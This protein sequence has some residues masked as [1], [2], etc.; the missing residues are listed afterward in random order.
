MERD[1]MFTEDHMFGA[2]AKYNV[3]E[4]PP[5]GYG[6][7][8]LELG[9]TKKCLHTA[10]CYRSVTS[11]FDLG[12][13]DNVCQIFQSLIAVQSID[14]KRHRC[15]ER[16]NSLLTD[17]AMLTKLFLHSGVFYH[18]NSGL[19]GISSLSWANESL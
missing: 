1:Y 17:L 14:T 3:V 6:Y 12:L 16:N 9:F 8:L 13:P 11:K 15:I 2:T 19:C 18:Q 4:I 10:K 5:T 7:G